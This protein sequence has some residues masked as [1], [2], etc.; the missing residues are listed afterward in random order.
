MSRSDRESEPTRAPDGPL[1]VVLHGVNLGL[2]GERP[3]GHYGTITLA[4]LEHLLRGEASARGWRC[5]CHQTDHE[6]EFV[7]L[8]HGYRSQA[9]AMLVNPGAWTHY[10]YAIHDALE[11]VRA[12]IAEV[13]L[14]DIKTREE[15]RRVSVIS[16]IVTL[17]VAG[18]GPAGYLRAA[19]TLMN[20]VAVEPGSNSRSESGANDRTEIGE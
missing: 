20:R 4:E 7:R 8:I 18:E 14:S 9:D 15:W 10:S 19:R 6:G 1:L 2:L 5:E 16:D 3:A 11:L 13:H 12:P 17:S